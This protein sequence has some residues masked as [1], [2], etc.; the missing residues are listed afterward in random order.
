[1]T[2]RPPASHATPWLTLFAVDVALSV[3]TLV[4]FG[5]FGGIFMLIALNGFGEQKGGAILFGYG[6]LVLACNT[7]VVGL[8]NWMILRVRRAVTVRGVIVPALVTSA[9][10][11]FVG[12]PLAI[13][14]INL[15]FAK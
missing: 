14:L 6:V 9:V 12:P 2:N 8:I 5:V 1:M 3:V 4:I 11:L 7:L 10:M 15:L 13:L